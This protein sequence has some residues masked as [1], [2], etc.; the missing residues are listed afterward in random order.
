M[1]NGKH[2]V[3]KHVNIRQNS[4]LKLKLGGHG[5]KKVALKDKMMSRRRYDH[6]DGAK[7]GS[8][9]AL[10]VLQGVTRV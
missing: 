10:V 2:A 5:S 9:M 8:S 4:S 6:H 7:S 1:P 3:Y